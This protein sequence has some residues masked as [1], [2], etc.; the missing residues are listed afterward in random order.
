MAFASDTLSALVSNERWD[1]MIVDAR[2]RAATQGAYAQWLKIVREETARAGSEYFDLKPFVPPGLPIARTNL[3][4]APTAQNMKYL[5]TC[6]VR[7]TPYGAVLP[8]SVYEMLGYLERDG[9]LDE[10][11]D[12]LLDRGYALAISV[13]ATAIDAIHSSAGGFAIPS[14]SGSGTDALCATHT[15]LDG[16]TPWD[17]SLTGAVSSDAVAD[18]RETLYGELDPAGVGTFPTAN[19]LWG[20]PSKE[21]EMNQAVKS[22]VS[23][24]SMQFNVNQGADIALLHGHTGA[25]WGMV[26]VPPGGPR[27]GG[28]SIVFAGGIDEANIPPALRG[29]GIRQSSGRPFA[30]YPIWDPIAQCFQIPY[31]VCMGV[32]AAVHNGVIASTGA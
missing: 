30:S 23:D 8:M 19:V 22:V 4:V 29:L 6:N 9:G 16:S 21:R 26:E 3:Y 2:A 20:P 1:E 14:T 15:L 13:L 12:V 5:P 24:G 11:M 28:M 7:L 18:M 27:R 31:G 10:L 17:N 25:D 32:G